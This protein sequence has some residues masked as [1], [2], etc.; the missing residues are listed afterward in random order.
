MAVFLSF[1]SPACNMATELTTSSV[2]CRMLTFSSCVN[3][4]NMKIVSLE[5]AFK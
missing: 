2:K 1:Y 4:C 3:L 5:L